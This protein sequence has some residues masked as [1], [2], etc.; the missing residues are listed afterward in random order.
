MDRDQ[1][2]KILHTLTLNYFKP[3]E[4]QAAQTEREQ[5]A[6]LQAKTRPFPVGKTSYQKL[7]NPNDPFAVSLG[8]TMSQT[9]VSDNSMHPDRVRNSLQEGMYQ[10]ACR[11]PRLSKHKPEEQAYSWLKA[12]QWYALRSLNPVQC[13]DCNESS[14]PEELQ[15]ADS[16]LIEAML[17]SLANNYHSR[18]F[19]L[20]RCP[21][22]SSDNLTHQEKKIPEFTDEHKA[23][24]IKQ[25]ENLNI[26]TQQ[27]VSSQQRPTYRLSLEMASVVDKD[28]RVDQS[29]LDAQAQWLQQ[30]HN[31]MLCMQ[32]Y[33]KL[34][35]NQFEQARDIE[36]FAS[37]CAAIIKHSPHVT[38]AF[39]ISQLFGFINRTARQQDLPPFHCSISKEQLTKNIIAAQVA[40]CKAMKAINPNLQTMVS[41][42]FKSFKPQHSFEEHKTSHAIEKAVCAI[43][44]R[45]YNQR[46]INELK[47]HEDSFDAIALSI[48]PALYFDK[49]KPM[50]DCNTS[51]KI[52]PEAALEAL[53]QAHK[54]FPSK[55][56]YIVE[57][58]CNSSDPAV[59]REFIDMTLHVCNVARLQLNIPVKGCYFWTQTND[60]QYYSEWNSP[61]GSTHF[62][63]F[64]RL[65]P[66]DPTSSINT[67]GKYLK[68][69]LTP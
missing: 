36:E 65:D 57:T 17:R 47:P 33:T 22:C 67:S 18:L 6:T 13:K 25:L 69:I 54:A 50:A 14:N 53:I 5:E 7:Q 61:K 56:L 41:H 26:F 30:F 10:E 40:A 52:D 16:H 2:A 11:Q 38:H 1:R 31:P 9:E 45:L 3:T 32:H 62:G 43:A 66:Q 51:G 20:T 63:F 23:A 35:D 49:W 44:D 8:S 34:R 68:E 12:R 42:Q 60:P 19:R 37:Y 48:Y 28:G 39:P 55:D 27:G 64:D 4:E 29:K 46:F 24:I 58:G 59:A 15:A 21:H